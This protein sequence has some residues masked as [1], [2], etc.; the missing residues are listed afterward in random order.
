M[1]F[2]FGKAKALLSEKLD[3]W[4]ELGLKNLPNFIVAV[5]VLV[6]FVV[7]AKLVRNVIDRI[8][9]RL[10]VNRS[11]S[12]LLSTLGYLLVVLM[13]LFISLG[14]L[15]LDKTVTSLLAGAGVLGLAIGFAAQEIAANFFSGVIIAFR[16][17]YKIGDIIEVS[18]YKGEVVSVNL[19]TTNI[20]TFDGL[21]VLVPN[22]LLF[23]EPFVNLTST[24][25]RR[26][27]L[28]VGVSYGDEIDKVPELIMR[29]LKDLPH[30]H[31]KK[32]S[33]VYFTEFGDSSINLVVHIWINYKKNTDFLKARHQAIINIKST[34]DKNDITIPFPIRTVDF[35]IK[36]GVN[37]SNEVKKINLKKMEKEDV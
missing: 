37:L 34:F 16:E 29:A 27:D 30:L 1:E 8:S 12:N 24:I 18:N 3:S 5:L 10:T 17:P 19:R 25:D 13:G 35:G 23:S 26:I 33:A 4:L 14:I 31:Q 6:A 11:V 15:N 20:R 7:A 28:N 2:N 21:E 32:K 22:R 36:G 9:S